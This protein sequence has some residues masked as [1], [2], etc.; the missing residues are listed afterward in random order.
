MQWP[1]AANAAQQRFSFVLGHTAAATAACTVL[2]QMCQHLDD[3]TVPTG[4]STHGL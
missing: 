4:M 1:E 3:Y 2:V